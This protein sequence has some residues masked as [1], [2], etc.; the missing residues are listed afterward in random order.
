MFEKY[1]RKSENI[2]D[3]AYP[4]IKNVYETKGNQYQN[5]VIPFTDGNRNINIIANLEKSYNNKGREL[6]KVFEQN[7][8]LSFID[9][10]WKD[11]LRQ[12][13]ELKHSVQMA[14]HE[15][16][17]P[18]LI[19]KFEAYELFKQMLSAVNKDVTTFLMKGSLPVQDANQI[20][21]HRQLRRAER[22]TET[23]GDGTTEEEYAGA[24]TA[25]TKEKQ[26]PARAEVKIGRNDP[27]PCGS[28][29]KFKQCHGKE[30]A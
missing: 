18:L 25:E 30:M 9:H 14:V 12:M 10:H 29:K 1:T 24:E 28:G 11:H 27:C 15:Q 7:I 20:Q 2:A 6:I 8:I 16:K 23:R 3:E 4:I 13:D 5:I 19:F 21:Q 17:D 22:T 26:Q